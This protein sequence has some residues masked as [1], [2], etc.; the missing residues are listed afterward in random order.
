MNV[1][2][3][4][5]IK[6]TIHEGER[7]LTVQGPGGIYGK[8]SP[9]DLLNIPK[10]EAVAADPGRAQVDEDSASPETP[11]RRGRKPKGDSE[12]AE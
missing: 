3:V 11:K 7:F 9:S 1:V 10:G 2:Q 4:T 12:G 5:V 8:I 6:E